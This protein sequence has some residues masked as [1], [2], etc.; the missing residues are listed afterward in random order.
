LGIK[1]VNYAGILPSF[2][3]KNKMLDSNKHNEM[4]GFIVYTAYKQ[5]S[6]TKFERLVPVILLGGAGSVGRYVQPHLK[7]ADVEYYVVDPATK[8]TSLPSHLR[9]EPAIV[10][11]TARKGVLESYIDQFWQELVVLNETFPEPSK[12]IQKLFKNRGNALFHLSGVQGKCYPSLPYGYRD[13]VPCCAIHSEAAE[14][15]PVVR[16]LNG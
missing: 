5:L 7:R 16:E 4:P 12:K 1:K 2:L 13:S 6:I 15:M 11:D 3:I 9:G 14:C 10:I 8:K